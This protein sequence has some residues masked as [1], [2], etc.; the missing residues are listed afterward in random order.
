MNR[1]YSKVFGVG[2]GKTGTT[3]LAK[4]LR[5]LGF[6]HKTQDFEL[7]RLFSEGKI[8]CVL[9]VAKHYESF[10]DYPWALAYKELYSAFPDSK[11]ILTTRL[12][13]ELW[14]RSMISQVHRKGINEQHK[15]VYGDSSP[16]NSRSEY[17][18]IYNNHN[19]GVRN[20]FFDKGDRFIELCWEKGDG[21]DELCDFLEIETKPTIDFPHANKS[22]GSLRKMYARLS[23]VLGRRS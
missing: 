20:F 7:V 22:P 1:S 8:D 5:T 16:E 15:M 19:E 18:D 6:K 23:K 2:L 14:L 12:D 17:I 13:S 11:F 10:E 3:S 21:W 4:C 9:E